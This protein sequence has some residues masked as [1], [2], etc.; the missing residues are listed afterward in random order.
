VLRTARLWKK[1]NWQKLCKDP[2][3]TAF[4]YPDL[5]FLENA[6]KLPKLD[7]LLKVPFLRTDYPLEIFRRIEWVKFLEVCNNS[8]DLTDLY[9]DYLLFNT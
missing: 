2:L 7:N 4:K 5:S 1:N 8:Y 9:L 6:L 3:A